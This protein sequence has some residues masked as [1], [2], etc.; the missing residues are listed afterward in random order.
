[1][2]VIGILLTFL[3][4]Y[5]WRA[6]KGPSVWDRLLSLNLVSTKIF[7]IV[8]LYASHTEMSFLLDIAIVCALLGFLSIVFISLF[9]SR[10]IKGEKK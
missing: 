5:I 8:I 3:T 1:M 2:L 4:V 6:Y 7:L 10:R 9:F